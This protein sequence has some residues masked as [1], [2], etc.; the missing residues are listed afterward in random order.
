[1]NKFK[2]I[3]A[4]VKKKSSKF[5]KPIKKIVIENPVLV[6]QLSLGPIIAISQSLKAG[7]SLSVA[8]SIIIIPVLT[9]FGFIPL[10]LSKSIRIILCS[11]LSCFFFI[12]ALWFAQ[13]IFPEVNDKVGIFLPL[14]VINPIISAKSADAAKGY[15][16]FTSM[17]SG[18]KTAVGFSLVMC[19]VSALREILGKGT[20]WDTPVLGLEGNVSYL[21]PF[22]GFIIVGLLAAG[23]KS[24]SIKYDKKRA[25][26]VR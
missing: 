10:K 9:I 24:I 20:I 15:H 6:S 21:L 1:M 3:L 13:T 7:V 18:I 4:V 11:L 23:V 19:F 16:P 14:M 5:V 26:E 12:P 2:K 17:L 22:M 25:K 8:F